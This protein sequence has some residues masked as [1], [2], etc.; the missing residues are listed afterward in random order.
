M[1]CQWKELPI[2]QHPLGQP[3][4]HC[5]NIYPAFRCYEA[6]GCFND[7]FEK[8]VLPLHQQEQLDV[9][10]THGDGTTTAAKKG[11]DNLS[12]SGHKHL[13]G[14]KVVAFCDC[15]FNVIAPFVTA[16]GNRNKFPLMKQALP[17]V[18][19]IARSIGLNL[20]GCIVSLD[21]AYDSGSDRKAIFN[22]GLIPNYSSQSQRRKEVPARHK[23]D[24]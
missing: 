8:S 9:S 2:V 17:M 15:N 24:I 5:T 7:I 18:T 20:E 1:G 4:I 23:A 12:F 6:H 13:K 22:R 3:E 21:G 11:G 19:H 16:P 10:V 14:D